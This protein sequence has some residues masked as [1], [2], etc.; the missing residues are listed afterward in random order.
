MVS[1]AKKRANK[2]YS[3]KTYKNLQVSVKIA[4]Y[5]AIDEYCRSKNISKANMI[6]NS[7][8]YCMENGIEFDNEQLTDDK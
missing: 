6:V 2:K 1:E 8:K 3:A 5:E 4:D 7:V